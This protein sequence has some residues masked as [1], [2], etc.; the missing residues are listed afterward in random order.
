VA[1]EEKAGKQPAAAAPVARFAA[2]KARVAS[3]KQWSLATRLR[4][5]LTFGALAVAFIGLATG[6]ALAF[7]PAKRL[8][9]HRQ[10]ASAF[11]ELDKGNRVTSRRI[12]ANLLRD[13]SIGYAEQG[14][15]YYILGTITQI[16][17]ASCR[18]RV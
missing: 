8:D 3:L 1:K 6:A 11:A 18:E 17:R 16:G 9:Y 15:A 10:L 2:L 7:R 13:A 5:I 14:G 12:A 4:A